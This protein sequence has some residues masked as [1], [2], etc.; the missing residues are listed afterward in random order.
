M[1]GWELPPYNSGGLGTASLGITQGLSSLGVGVRFVVPKVFGPYPF[2]HMPVLSAVDH[3]ESL[4]WDESASR[5]L[6]YHTE[7][8]EIKGQQLA[9]PTKGY[10]SAQQQSDWYAE[11]VLAISAKEAPPSLIHTHDWMTYRAGLAAR[12]AF[13]AR[14]FHTPMVAHIHAT[15]F[16]RSDRHGNPE[17]YALEKEGLNGADRVV[18]VSQ[19]TA[20][21][22]H[23][24]YG[25]PLE[26]IRVVHNGHT[27][28]S[29]LKR[30][31]HPLKGRHPV[32]LFMGRV[33]WQKGPEHFLRFA[34]A[35]LKLDPSVR[36]I[37]AGSGDQYERIIEQAA[38]SQLSGRVL[39]AP[40]LRG[41]EVDRAYQLADLFVMPSESEPFGLVALEAMEHG[42]PV[43]AS[44][45]CGVNEVAPSIVVTDHT[46][47]LAMARAAHTI[48][49]TDDRAKRLAAMQHDLRANS[50]QVACQKL[51]AVYDE[52]TTP[53][54]AP[55]PVAA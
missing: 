44:P 3:G 2:S 49:H 6:G 9:L 8:L 45:R 46:N 10:L 43:L 16:D 40:F 42:T 21:I 23:E 4:P 35:L 17:I 55:V 37:F 48:L 31:P 41:E 30:H 15:E 27:A 13:H 33:T 32:V 39:F 19:L 5:Q 38:G 28:R 47:P 50:W 52:L 25:V 22:V 26:K 51:Q 29:N 11:K 34:V 12:D 1:L 20:S 53:A 36:F 24:E 18:A 7:L 14:G 54:L